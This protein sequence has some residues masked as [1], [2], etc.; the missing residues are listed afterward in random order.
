MSSIKF[1]NGYT[2]PIVGLGT[3]QSSDPQ[4]LETALDEALK[5]GY[6]HIDTAYMYENEHIIGKVLKRWFDSGNI[7]RDELF[8]V[9]KLPPIGM[10]PEKVEY[11]IQKSLKALQLDYLDLYLIHLPVGLQYVSDT[12]LWPKDDSGKVLINPNSSI[13][14]V[15]KAMEVQVDNGLTRSIGISNFRRTQ[16]ERIM[17]VARIQPANQQIE[18]HAY[19]QR[20]ELL[21]TCRKYN[22]TVV[23]YA[24]LGSPGRKQLYEKRGQAFEPI[25]L[26][27][28]DVVVEIANRH[29]KS[30]SQ[31]LMKYWIQQN[32]AVIPKSINPARVRSNFDLFSFELSSDEMEKLKTLDKGPSGR[33]FTMVMPGFVDHPE[34]GLDD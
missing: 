27:E 30:T 32:V 14:A 22:I 19:F 8:V 10:T 20:P 5:A 17:K 34:Y 16:V 29:S 4:E 18:L 3:W 23:A 24:P 26:L 9:T 11:F 25:P 7:K 13:E 2:M 28:D 31:I 15:W 33:T 21:E 6:R 12:D 1:F